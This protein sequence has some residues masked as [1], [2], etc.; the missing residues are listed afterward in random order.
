MNWPQHWRITTV[1]TM[2]EAQIRLRMVIHAG[3]IVQDEYGVAGTALNLAFRLLE[4][5]PL[6]A[7]LRSSAGVLAAIASQW[8]FD[9]VIRNDP[10]SAPESYRPVRISVKE[11]Q[12]TAWICLPDD[13]F[14]GPRASGDA[15]AAAA[16]RAEA[17]SG[18][19]LRVC[20]AEGRVGRAH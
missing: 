9:E 8:Y 10:A 1:R 19:D 4:A 20:W 17:A 12:A 18:R 5:G 13:A 7:A 16:R 3:E 2:L 6:K 11:T 15:V 14:P